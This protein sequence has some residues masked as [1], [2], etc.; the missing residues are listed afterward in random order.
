MGKTSVGLGLTT[1]QASI[2]TMN[3]RKNRKSSAFFL[4]L[5][6]FLLIL[7]YLMPSFTANL[8]HT[9]ADKSVVVTEVFATPVDTVRSKIAHV[10]TI[11]DVQKHNEMLASENQRLLE[12]FQAAN[13]LDAENRALRELLNMKDEDAMQFRSGKVM[14]D[15]ATQYSHTILVQLGKNDGLSKGQGVL[16]HEGLIGRVI[17]TG[18]ET[19]RILLMSDVNSR[20]PV[21]VE[22][23]KDRAILAGTNNTDP[24]LDHLP[25]S[26]S[27]QAGQKV[28]TSG[29]GGIFPY[30]VPVGEIYE[31]EAGQLAV[32]PFASPNRANYV[33][34]VDYGIPAGSA[35]RATASTSGVLR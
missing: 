7:N 18:Q 10:Q 9:V 27:I 6:L 26:H 1:R 15:Q 12:W 22:G 8:K 11:W 31:T 21:T 24:V 16:S 20:I 4:I 19:S 3:D 17:E 5:S 25:D 34:I 30:G 13:R 32:K 23:T 29:H 2:S 28:I 33:Q 35:T 14:S